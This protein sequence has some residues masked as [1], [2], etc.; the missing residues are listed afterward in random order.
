MNIDAAD[1]ASVVLI[2]A[3]ETTWTMCCRGES[4]QTRSCRKGGH[5]WR[6]SHHLRGTHC[7]RGNRVGAV[8]VVSKRVGG[9]TGVD[10]LRIVSSGI[11]LSIVSSEVVS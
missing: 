7:W 6:E 3:E 1:A 9:G 10:G 4:Y 8:V 11:K 2:L 5:C